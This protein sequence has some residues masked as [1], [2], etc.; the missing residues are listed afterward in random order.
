LWEFFDI[1]MHFLS[2]HKTHELLTS[3]S[4]SIWWIGYCA[5]IPRWV[6]FKWIRIFDIRRVAIR[7]RAYG[8]M[9]RHNYHVSM[10]VTFFTFEVFV[11][12]WLPSEKLVKDEFWRWTRIF[13]VC[14]MHS[15]KVICM[16]ILI[17]RVGFGPLVIVGEH[18]FDDLIL[19]NQVRDH[20]DRISIYQTDRTVFSKTW[21]KTQSKCFDALGPVVSSLHDSFVFWWDRQW[22]DMLRSYESVLIV[23]IKVAYQVVENQFFSFFYTCLYLLYGYQ[24]NNVSYITHYMFALWISNKQCIIYHMYLCYG[25]QINNVSYIT[26]YMTYD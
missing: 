12:H 16:F 11:S 6:R 24:I 19:A 9:I 7:V 3:T 25:Y 23:T 4:T 8:N 13:H 22:T 17:S 18:V 1:F 20:L 14:L 2:S 21:V 15:L 5:V 26:H 10:S